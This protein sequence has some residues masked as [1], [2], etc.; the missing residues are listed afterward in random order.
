VYLG[1]IVVVLARW[2]SSGEEEGI[3]LTRAQ[4]YGIVCQE[5]IS[6]TGQTDDGSF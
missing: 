1:A 4:R 5:A 6:M 2:Y 3:Y